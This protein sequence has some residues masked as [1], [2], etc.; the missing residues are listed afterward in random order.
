MINYN[1]VF[2]ALLGSFSAHQT[3]AREIFAELNLTEAQP[4]LLYILYFNDGIVQKDFAGLCSCKESTMTVHINNLESNGF[5]YKE[6]ILVSGHKHANKIFLTE[7]GKETAEKLNKKIEELEALCTKNF[8]DREKKT[9]LKLLS[10]LTENLE[11]K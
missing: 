1:K 6:S 11:N 8:T 2:L 7:K 4:K 5:I 3:K 9:L 10:C